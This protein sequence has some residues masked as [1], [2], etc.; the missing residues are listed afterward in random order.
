M[1]AQIE[2]RL[3]DLPAEQRPQVVLVSVDP[4]RDTPEQLASV[5]EVLQIRRSS[6]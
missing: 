2:K 5:R 1:L 3:A 4:E 6:A